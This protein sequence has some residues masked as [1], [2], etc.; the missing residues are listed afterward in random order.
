MQ[1]YPKELHSE[2]KQKVP[3]GV[4]HPLLRTHPETGKHALYIHLGFIRPDSLF[5]VRTGETLPPDECK[6]I[7][8][9]LSLQHGREEYV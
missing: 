1:K 9:Q 5:D 8:R 3:F 4:S 6:D 7:I 2:I